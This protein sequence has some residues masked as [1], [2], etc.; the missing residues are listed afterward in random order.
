[1][2]GVLVLWL[3]AALKLHGHTSHD[4]RFI[5]VRE[6]MEEKLNAGVHYREALRQISMGSITKGE[7]LQNI[8]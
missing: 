8:I 5:F 7:K 1:M 2:P 3:R 4:F 6:R